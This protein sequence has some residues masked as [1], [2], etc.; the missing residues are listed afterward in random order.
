M[1]ERL[2]SVLDGDGVCAWGYRGWVMHGVDI[3]MRGLN[4]WDYGANPGRFGTLGEYYDPGSM[5]PGGAHLLMADGS[6]KFFMQNTDLKVFQALG[7]MANG[8]SETV[9]LP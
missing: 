4:H 8:Q 2:H 5:H 7:T 1:A 9:Q 6:V 3:T